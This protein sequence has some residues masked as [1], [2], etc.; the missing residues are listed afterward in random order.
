MGE[1]LEEPLR[2]EFDGRVRL[3]FV[4][5]KI[6]SDAGVLACRE[7][8]EKLVKIGARLTRHARRLM[9]QMA[10][11]AIPRDVF[12]QILSRVRLLSLVPT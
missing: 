5:S 3:E 6:S 1:A 9:V 8:D 7:L 11:V 12:G 10:D 2:V 4:G